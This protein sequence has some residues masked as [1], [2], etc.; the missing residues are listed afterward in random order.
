MTGQDGSYLAEFLLA[1]G[2]EV[3]G[4]VRRIVLEDP[5][6]RMSRIAHI[7]DRIHLHPASVENLPGLYRIFLSVR[8]TNAIT[9]L[10]RAS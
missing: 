5:V 6:H 9:W 1:R 4:I 7:A 3:H 10:R 2:Y 8:P